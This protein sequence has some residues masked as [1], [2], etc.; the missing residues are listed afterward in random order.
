MKDISNF[1]VLM[2]LF[3]FTYAILG[4]ELFAFKIR[5]DNDGNPIDL[6]N[7][8]LS[9]IPSTGNSPRENFDNFLNAIT[10]IFI[11]LIGDVIYRVILILLIGLEQYHV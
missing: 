2:F 11:I 6:K 3:I 1:I 5:F 10:T 4:M 7:I 9:D 8:K